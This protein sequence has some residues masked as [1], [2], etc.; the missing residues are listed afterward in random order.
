MIAAE[1]RSSVHSI[2]NSMEMLRQIILATSMVSALAR[3]AM[4]DALPL[5]YKPPT[6]PRLARLARIAGTVTIGFAIDS[7]GRIA[8]IEIISGHPLLSA[9]AKENL[10]TWRFTAPTGALPV[11]SRRVSYIFELSSDSADG[12]YDPKHE[13]F[14]FEGTSLV[15]V[16]AAPMGTLTAGDCPDERAVAPSGQI[17]ET[18]SVSLRRSGCYGTCPS[19]E[20]TLFGNGHI[21]WKGD[22]F[23]EAIGERTYSIDRVVAE[24][25]LKRFRSSEVLSLCGEY[26]RSV[27]DSASTLTE[28]AVSNIR[29]SIHDYASSS[30]PWFQ[31]LLADLDSATQSH[32]MRHGDPV[33][34]PLINIQGEYLPK[35]GVTDLMRSAARGELDT[36]NQLITS[37][38]RLE[39]TDASGWTALMYAAASY[40]SGQTLDALLRAGANRSHRSSFGDTVLMSAALKGVFDERLA[41]GTGTINAQNRDGVTALMLLAARGRVDEIKAALKAGA[42][43]TLKDQ[44]GRSAVDYL[45]AIPCRKSLVRGYKEFLESTG[46]C[47][48]LNGELRK[49]RG[50]LLSAGKEKY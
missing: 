37:G 15:R 43:A 23:V 18:D 47:S 34:E 28:I 9:A 26:S 4:Q 50:L 35:P 11:E 46:P 12:Y 20:I 16:R 19:Y 29:K 39:D 27:T 13:R 36:L 22:A 49:A 30:P 5:S 8:A 32:L 24:Q 44:H 2:Q 1:V 21:R 3:G 6:Y 14:S 33:T 25:I 45:D 17:L 41:Q 10:A 40:S 42:S 38:A 31:G 7:E 48:K